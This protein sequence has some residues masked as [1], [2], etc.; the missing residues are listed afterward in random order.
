MISRLFNDQELRRQTAINGKAMAEKYFD[1][2]K[3]TEQMIEVYESIVL[4][5]KR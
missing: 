2:E 5:L 4:S 3:V 1:I